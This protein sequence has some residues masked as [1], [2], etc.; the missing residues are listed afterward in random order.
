M[1]KK[2]KFIENANKFTADQAERAA[3]IVKDLSVG[4]T[5]INFSEYSED[6]E[7]LYF[8]WVLKNGKIYVL[9][10]PTLSYLIIEE[11]PVRTKFTYDDYGKARK[12]YLKS[13]NPQLYAELETAHSLDMHLADIDK[14]CKD[15]E[16]KLMEQMC[17]D[18]G[19]TAELKAANAME[20]VGRYKNLLS[21][22]R[23]MVCDDIVYTAFS[24][25]EDSDYEEE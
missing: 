11:I 7:E 20:W 12:E 19:I 25:I 3:E 1:D 23:E 10:E 2:V 14:I 4:D 13:I 24:S 15:A 17:A 21:R 9:D 8:K 6:I 18:E 22:V 5:Y 16:D